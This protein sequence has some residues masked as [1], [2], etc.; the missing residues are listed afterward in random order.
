MKKIVKIIEVIIGIIIL[1]G[2]IFFAIDYNRAKNNEQP[3]FCVQIDEANDGGTKIYL[4]L[5]YKVIDFNTLSGF[6]DV[7]IGTWFMDYDDFNDEINIVEH[8]DR[9]IIQEELS[10]YKKKVNFYLKS[11]LDNKVINKIRNNEKITKKDI[12][13]LEQ[14]LFD[15]LNSNSNEFK[16]NYN[17]ESLVLLV[18][19]TVGLSKEAIDREFSKYI[20]E[21][22]L[23]FEQTRFVNL[24]KNYIMK[25]GVIDKR[26]LNEDPFTNYGSITELFEGQINILQ[27]IV[28]IIDLINQNG[29]FRDESS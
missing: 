16:I 24:I 3:M 1:L 29:C 23:N 10:D 21:N 22:E 15:D 7:K 4:G 14:I 25:N 9:K 6:D 5:G 19:K 27:I 28:M 20:N 17:D 12:E 2:I 8:D 11:H 13:N 18:R 26:I